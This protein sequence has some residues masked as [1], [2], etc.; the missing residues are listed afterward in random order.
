VDGRFL[1][2]GSRVGVGGHAV[3][4]RPD[5]HDAAAFVAAADQIVRRP[6]LHPRLVLADFRALD[7]VDPDVFARLREHLT[8]HR[9]RVARLEL[10]EALLHPDGIVGSIVAGFYSV[11]PKPRELC[12]NRA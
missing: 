4:G 11:A 6:D 5:A 8:K 7:S 3:W 2:W 12:Q 9:E 10:R 1:C